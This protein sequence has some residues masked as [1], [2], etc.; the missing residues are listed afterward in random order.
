MEQGKRGSEKHTSRRREHFSPL[1][2]FIFV[3]ITGTPS[4]LLPPLHCSIMSF[5]LPFTVP[6]CPSTSPSLFHLP[7]YLP[8]TVPSPLLPPLH[9]SI[10]PSTSPSLFHLPFYLPF[11]VPSPLLPPLHCSISPSTSPSLFHLPFYLPFIV[12]SCPSLIIER[13]EAESAVLPWKANR[14]QVKMWLLD[15]GYG[16]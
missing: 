6:S 9:C 5:Y 13:P 4:P 11:T 8:F 12:P 7:F 3:Q 10:S 16:G 1:L 15:Q 2:H 14:A